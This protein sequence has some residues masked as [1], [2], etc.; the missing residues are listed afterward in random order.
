MGILASMAIGTGFSILAGA[1]VLLLVGGRTDGSGAVGTT[2]PTTLQGIVLS[3]AG[4]IT[5]ESQHPHVFADVRQP[6]TH[7]YRRNGG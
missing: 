4:T 2:N 5:P 7:A 6:A 3:Q 1:L